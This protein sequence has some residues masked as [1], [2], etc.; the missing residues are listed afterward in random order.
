MK[1]NEII[2]EGDVLNGEQLAKVTG[3]TGINATNTNHGNCKCVGGD[4]DDNV[5][6]GKECLCTLS[7]GGSGGDPLN[8]GPKC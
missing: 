2:K 4:D 8:S 7:P 5:N 1:I 6:F 3:G